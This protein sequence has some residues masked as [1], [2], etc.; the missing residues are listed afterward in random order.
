MVKNLSVNWE[1]G[2]PGRLQLTGAGAVH[3]SEAWDKPAECPFRLIF[4]YLKEI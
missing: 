1:K 3:S 4:F 2:E